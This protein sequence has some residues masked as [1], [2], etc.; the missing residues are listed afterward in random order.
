M[1]KEKRK[2]KHQPPICN[3]KTV[4]KRVEKSKR[5]LLLFAFLRNAKKP[6]TGL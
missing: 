4:K 6:E 1:E 2:A 5:Y 3:S